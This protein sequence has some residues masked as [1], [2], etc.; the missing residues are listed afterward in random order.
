MLTGFEVE[1]GFL[2]AG[3]EVTGIVKQLA[4]QLR[5]IL[6]QIQHSQTD[7]RDDR[8]DAVREQ[9]GPR[10]V[11]QPVDDFLAGG[12]KSTTGTAQ[13]FTEGAGDDID[14]ARDTAMFGCA[15]PS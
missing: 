3:A 4:A 14:T 12:N 13:R 10:P 11:A 6:E 1:A 9:V 5:C 2:Q 15:T 8:R 7:T